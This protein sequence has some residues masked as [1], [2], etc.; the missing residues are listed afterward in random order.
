MLV[1]Q[2]DPASEGTILC[3]NYP[4]SSGIYICVVIERDVAKTRMLHTT[5]RTGHSSI[6]EQFID[7]L[8]CPELKQENS[9]ISEQAKS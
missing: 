3:K 4:N 7:K 2:R 1:F 9:F 6:L 5:Q 8:S